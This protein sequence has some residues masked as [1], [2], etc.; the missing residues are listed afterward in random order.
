[1]RIHPKKPESTRIYQ[2]PSECI[3]IHQNLSPKRR[4]AAFK[5]SV[6]RRPSDAEPHLNPVTDDAQATLSRNEIKHGAEPIRFRSGSERP[7]TIKTG[8]K[9]LD[10]PRRKCRAAVS[11]KIQHQTGDAE[12][13]EDQGSSSGSGSQ[14]P[15]RFR[16]QDPTGD[17]TVRVATGRTPQWTIGNLFQPPLEPFIC[18]WTAVREKTIY[19]HDAQ[20]S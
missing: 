3:R 10:A 13:L 19:I 15:S 6:R 16:I 5:S 9:K 8:F 11:S 12:Q 14:T 20:M 7:A 18:L 4:R 17:P 1:M 2:N